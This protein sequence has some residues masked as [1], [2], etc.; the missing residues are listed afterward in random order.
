M[1]KLVSVADVITPNLTE[2]CILC[3]TD[4]SELIKNAD[5]PDFLDTVAELA[6]SF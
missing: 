6:K 5:S 1:K 4:Y 3:D 2:C